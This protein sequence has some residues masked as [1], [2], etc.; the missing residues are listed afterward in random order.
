MLLNQVLSPLDAEAVL[1]SIPREMWVD[2]GITA[3]GLARD[4]K[5]ALT[6]PSEETRVQDLA[7]LVSTR[8]EQN[9]AFQR[10]AL[11]AA[12]G[13]PR[14]L[15]Y[16][17]GMAYG[18]HLDAVFMQDRRTDLSYTI[19]LTAAYQGGELVIELPEGKQEVKGGVGDMYLYEAGRIHEV[20]EVSKG[21]RVV[22]VGWVQSRIPDPEAR[23]ELFLLKLRIDRLKKEEKNEEI[24]EHQRLYNFLLRRFSRN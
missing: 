17:E 2:G 9:K 6:L 5:M 19:F 11:P 12:M 7:K 24:L 21:L 16:E 3:G 4:V 1:S 20:R 8:I 22:A 13:E 15:L 14:F 18:R 23:H 10:L